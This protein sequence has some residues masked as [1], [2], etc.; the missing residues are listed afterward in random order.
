M[1]CYEI[2]IDGK[3]ADQPAVSPTTYATRE[4]AEAEL[5]P[6]LD[7]LASKGFA[8]LSWY[9]GEATNIRQA[10]V[11]E[12]DEQRPSDSGSVPDLIERTTRLLEGSAGQ[13][14]GSGGTA[15]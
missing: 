14:H 15:P 11:R 7:V 6:L 12:A 2:V 8:R 3:G 10:F 13:Q 5:A 1:P 4:E 9:G